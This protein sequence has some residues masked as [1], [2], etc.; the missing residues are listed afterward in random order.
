MIV[1][2]H[3]VF[4]AGAIGDKQ[5]KLVEGTIQDRTRQAFQNVADRLSVIGLGLEDGAPPS[6]LLALGGEG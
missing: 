3:L 2:G 6:A 5:G 4:L 1:S